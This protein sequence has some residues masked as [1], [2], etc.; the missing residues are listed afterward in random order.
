MDVLVLKI[1]GV[2]GE[3]TLDGYEDQIICHS[4]SHNVVNHLQTNVSNVGRSRGRVEHGDFVLS[5]NMDKSSPLLEYK[6][7]IGANLGQIVFTVLRTGGESPHTPMMIYTM[8]NAMVSSV[9]TSGGGG[10]TPVETVTFN[11]TKIR[12]EYKVQAFD[13][14]EPGSV[15]ADWDVTLNAGE[16][17]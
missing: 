4:Y 9:A 11:Y 16:P 6:C 10:D 5:K 7:C 15:A 12:W 17:S 14:T 2:E 1:D 8:D 3:C 13:V